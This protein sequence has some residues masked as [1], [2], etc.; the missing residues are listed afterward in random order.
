MAEAVPPGRA[1]R[2]WLRRRLASARRSLDLL[3]RKRQ[4]LRRELAD[5][6]PR[7]R[8]AAE[9]WAGACLEAER[10]GVRATVLGGAADV[11]LAAAGVEGRAAV[12]VPWD[13]TMGVLHPAGPRCRLPVLSPAEAAAGNAA[14]AP[15]AA[16]YRR[17]L[18]AAAAH[19]ALERSFHLIDAELR[20]TERRRRAIE[21]HRL[22]ALEDAL[23]RLELRLDELERE[24]RVV[25][26]WA[27]RRHGASTRGVDTKDRRR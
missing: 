14:V 9:D 4:L 27:Q 25:G 11:A 23:A 18:D 8:Q 7:R 5:L 16:A 12:D 17:A 15:A 13:N 24:E 6:A 10:W 20:A 3:D 26:H 22:P 2:L 21:R 19:G 1:G